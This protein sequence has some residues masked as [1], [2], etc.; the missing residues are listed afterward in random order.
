MLPELQISRM[1]LEA[2]QAGCSGAHEGSS[3]RPFILGPHSLSPTSPAILRNQPAPLPVLGTRSLVLWK[4]SK[5]FADT[6]V[7]KVRLSDRTLTRR[8]P[9]RHFLSTHSK[10][11]SLPAASPC[12]VFPAGQSW[13]RKPAT[14]VRQVYGVFSVCHHQPA[15]LGAGTGLDLASLCLTFKKEGVEVGARGLRNSS[16]QFGGTVR[17]PLSPKGRYL[18]CGLSHPEEL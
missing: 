5:I 15:A 16:S 7:G 13:E 3:P 1:Q 18:K 4:T 10:S 9:F 8:R 11:T 6:V 2:H 12:L 14:R 17:V